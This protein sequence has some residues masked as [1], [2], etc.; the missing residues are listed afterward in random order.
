MTNKGEVRRPELGNQSRTR[1]G[2]SARGDPSIR[3]KPPFTECADTKMREYIN[4]PIRGK[5]PLIWCRC[6]LIRG[7]PVGRLHRKSRVRAAKNS[8]GFFGVFIPNGE[9]FGQT[10]ERINTKN[11]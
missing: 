1:H 2:P 3:G 7:K 9:Y 8:V 6:V 11:T 10:L 4:V 5:P